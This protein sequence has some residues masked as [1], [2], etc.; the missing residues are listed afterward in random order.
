MKTPIQNR[1]LED[2]FYMEAAL[3]VLSDLETDCLEKYALTCAEI[4][5]RLRGVSA[6]F[7]QE[8]IEEL[9]QS[10]EIKLL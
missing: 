4:R 1:T 6:E 10:D 3:I 5:Y 8:S 7:I 2:A 9:Q